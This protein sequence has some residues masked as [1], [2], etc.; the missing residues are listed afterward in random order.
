MWL[1]LWL[2]L[3]WLGLPFGKLSPM[4]SPAS[5]DTD[6]AEGVRSLALRFCKAGANLNQES[7][8]ECAKLAEVLKAYLR[9]QAEN[10]A[11]RHP[12]EAALASYISDATSFRCQSTASGS[13]HGRAVVRKGKVLEE[14]LMER[15]CVYIAT[16]LGG[17]DVAVVVADPRPLSKGKKA[18][19]LFTAGAKFFPMLRSFGRTGI[20]IFHLGTDRAVLSSLDRLFR[21][22]QKAFYMPGVG[23][24]LGDEA[25]MFEKTDWYI[26]TGCAL[27]DVSNAIQWGFASISGGEVLN[28]IHIVIE[29]CRNS[30]AFIQANIAKFLVR[31]LGF[32]QPPADDEPVL[33]FWRAMGVDVGWLDVLGFLNPWWDGGRLLV[34]EAAKDDPDLIGKVSDVILYL[35]RWRKFVVT[36]WATVG[37]SCRALVVSLCVGLEEIVA[38]TLADESSSNFYLHGFSKLSKDVKKYACVTAIASYP[39]DCLQLQLL[40][41]DRVASRPQELKEAFAEEARWVEGLDDFTWGRLAHIAGGGPGSSPYELRSAALT[42]V[43]ISAAYI[44]KKLFNVVEELP[45]CLVV[46]DVSLNLQRLEDEGYDGDDPTVLKIVELMHLGYNRQRLVEGVS[47]LRDVPWSTVTVEQA[48]GSMAAIHRLHPTMSSEVLAHRTMVHQCRNLFNKTQEAKEIERA[49]QKAEALRSRMPQRT[50]AKQ[51]FLRELMVEAKNALT[52][53]AKMSSQLRQA[54]MRQHSE[55]FQALD[56]AQQRAL[57]IRAQSHVAAQMQRTSD[58]LSHIK[59]HVALHQ[60]RLTQELSERGLTNRLSEHRFSEDAL[61]TIGRLLKSRDFLPAEV[62]LLRAKA[63]DA[64]EAPSEKQQA[65]LEACDVPRKAPEGLAFQSEWL[66]H[67]CFRRAESVGCALFSGGLDL[68]S[69]AYLFLYAT[70]KPQAAMFLELH[71]CVRQIPMAPSLTDLL[72][73]SACAIYEFEFRY[74]PPRYCQECDLPFGDVGGLFVLPDLQ[75]DP[76]GHLCTD[77]RPVPWA[78]FAHDLPMPSSAPKKAPAPGPSRAERQELME[79]HPW[80]REELGLQGPKAPGIGQS[81]GPPEETE[82]AVN[83][84]IEA[85]MKEV[86]NKRRLWELESLDRLEDFRTKV[87]GDE[88]LVCDT[89]LEFASIAGVACGASAVAW[90]RTYGMIKQASFSHRDYTYLDASRMALEWCRRMQHYYDIFKSQDDPTYVYSTDDLESYVEEYEWVSYLCDLDIESAAWSRSE[91]I[92]TLVPNREPATSFAGA[93]SSSKR[94]RS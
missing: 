20:V 91:A 93:A 79:L 62:K 78:E 87:L 76:S 88:S 73:S 14:F 19:N 38:L 35:W 74:N 5:A 4:A 3:L 77:S 70:L 63:R 83:D 89:K 29:S 68:G 90:C 67:F 50:H 44:Q 27:H 28:D 40:E 39:A 86:Y 17:R 11:K 57:E 55:L 6:T 41:D 7:E 16:P 81:S 9:K 12:H 13:S 37:P 15:I 65:A 26:T 69:K 31:R 75:F 72:D 36:R 60:A 52:P 51:L 10:T 46:G 1:A 80:L 23:P 22:R 42:A 48:H 71:R 33:R 47:L 92:R 59:T 56:P 61:L 84:A 24:D 53:G 49:E 8:D 32:A 64:P 2:A 54:L 25:A 21:Q 58:D 18:L 82:D 43:H 66:R 85:A 30:F 45:W 34:S 94:R